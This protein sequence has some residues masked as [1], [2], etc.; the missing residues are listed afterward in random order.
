MASAFM[1]RQASMMDWRFSFSVVVCIN[2]TGVLQRLPLSQK[3]LAAS[4]Q[5]LIIASQYSRTL[6]GL[7]NGRIGL[8]AVEISWSSH[9]ECRAGHYRR[10]GHL[11]PAG[12]GKR[13]R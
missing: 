13:P 10:I 8:S 4:E 6:A 9:D 2:F 3:P 7:W 12:T 11:R 5:W 1:R